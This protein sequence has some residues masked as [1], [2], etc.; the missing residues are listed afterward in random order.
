MNEIDLVTIKL[1]KKKDRS[2]FKRIYDFYSPFIWKIA[3]RTM[4]G[5]AEAAGEA[6]QDT[7]IRVHESLHK[8]SGE[9]GLS[10]WLYRIVFN[11]C[12]TALAKQKKANTMQPLS[13]NIPAGPSAM[14]TLDSKDQ[15]NTILAGM[16]AD[17]RF[18][19]TGREMLGLSYEDLSQITGKNAGSLRTQPSR[20]KDGI[21]NKFKE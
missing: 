16:T 19:L 14:D 18:L 4:H 8:F 9:S 7:F 20:L 15:V 13:E 5:D 3:Y 10:T 11:V 6:V 21:R 17:E 12:L 1:A 2:A